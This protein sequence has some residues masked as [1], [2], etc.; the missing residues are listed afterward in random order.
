[1]V[2]VSLMVPNDSKSYFYR[3]HKSCAE[4]VSEEQERDID[5]VLI[6]AIYRAKLGSN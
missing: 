6:D 5:S 2:T 4:L 3:M 1:M